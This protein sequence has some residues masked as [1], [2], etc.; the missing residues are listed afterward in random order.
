VLAAVTTVLALGAVA[1]PA[2]TA[3]ADTPQSCTLDISTGEY[4][5]TPVDAPAGSRLARPAVTEATSYVLARFYDSIDLDP[6][7]GSFTVTASAPCDT[8]SD[9]DFTLGTVPSGWN[10][11]VSSFQGFNNCS[12]R[13]WRN[14]GASGTYWGPAFLA[15]VLGGMDNQASSMTFY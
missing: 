1:A 5:C 8:S 9:V 6:S 7:D 11:R 15:N 3:A 13:L 10:D 12:V 2:A 4:W 14:G